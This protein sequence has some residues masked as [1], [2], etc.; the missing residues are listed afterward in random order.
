M[1][2]ER[3]ISASRF[4]SECL[5]LLDEVARQGSTLVITKRGRPVARVIAAAPPPSLEGSVT[6]HVSDDELLAPLDEPW[7]AEA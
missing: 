7:E 1:M 4:K 6:Y 5:A 3:T 2:A